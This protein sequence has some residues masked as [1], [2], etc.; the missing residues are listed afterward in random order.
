MA[1]ALTN[2]K[3][4]AMFSRA[5]KFIPTRI[6]LFSCL[7]LLLWGNLTVNVSDSATPAGL[8]RVK[9][10]SKVRLGDLVYLRMPIKSVWA[11]PG[12]RVTFTPQ[13]VY[14]NGELIPNSVPEP[15]IP[16]RF[17]YGNYTVPP[18][19][20][21]GMG[22]HNPDSWDSRYVGFLP[23][24]IVAGKVSPIWTR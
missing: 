5:L 15:G 14:R 23:L 4:N 24:S 20:F 1:R 7:V 6:I 10:I 9:P 11:L 13:G 16:R 2:E 17:P 3:S 8:Y 21:L 22:T 18:E 19:M 12:D